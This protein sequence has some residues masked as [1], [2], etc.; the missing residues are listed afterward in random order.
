MPISHGPSGTLHRP[1]ADTKTTEANPL[2]LMDPLIYFLPKTRDHPIR[3][4]IPHDDRDNPVYTHPFPQF[5]HRLVDSSLILTL[6]FK[7]LPGTV[8]HY[9]IKILQKTLYFQMHYL[10]WRITHY[11]SLN[12]KIWK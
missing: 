8:I 2:W 6:E 3:I 12:A 11:F 7:M 9:Q 5:R 10:C 4:L 1:S